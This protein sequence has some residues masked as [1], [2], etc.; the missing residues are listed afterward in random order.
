MLAGAI[1]AAVVAAAIAALFTMVLA[2]RAA[3]TETAAAPAAPAASEPAPSPEPAPSAEPAREPER[4][5]APTPSAS[6]EPQAPKITTTSARLEDV[7]T[8]QVVPTSL[9]VD[10]MGVAG[11]PIDPVGVE[12]DDS[13]EIPVDIQRI[14][15]YEY[16]PAPGDEAGSAVLT[17]HIDSRTQGKGVFYHL[18]ALDPGDIVEVGMSD[19]TTRTF[20]VDDTQQIPKVDL[21]TGDVFRRDGAPRLALITCGGAF[22]SSSRHYQDNI[23]VYATPNG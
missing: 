20:T 6:P 15:W 21:P 7:Q 17:A 12:P 1:T 3:P 8:E 18:D 22:D 11:A 13:M 16:G 2:Q 5:P 14:G 10:A 9:S 19:G 4:Q 23:V